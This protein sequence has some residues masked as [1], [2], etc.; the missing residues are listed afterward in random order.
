MATVFYADA[1]ELATLTNTFALDSVAT[2]P[3][4]V[5]LTVTDPTGDATTYT[6]ADSEITKAATGVYTKDIAV[7]TAGTWQYLWVGTGAVSDAT[8]GIWHV[9]PSGLPSIINLAEARGWLRLSATDDDMELAEIL[10]AASD[11]CEDMTGQVWRRR[12]ITEVHDTPGDSSVITLRRRP[13]ESITQVLVSGSAVTDYVLDGR[14]GR[15]H[16][17]QAIGSL[18]WLY[19]VQNTSIT[20]VAAPIDGIVPAHIRRGLKLLV[21]HIWQTQRGGL[22]RQAG[23][24]SQVAVDPRT[25]YSFPRRVLEMW[26]VSELAGPM[27][28]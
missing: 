25:G 5:S 22:P 8:A 16:R 17:G 21:Q 26:G 20:Y 15:L 28:G 14:R 23:A 12:T 13:V 10:L 9:E 3:D 2:D 18:P 11:I 4:A 27:V 24:S 7:P 6:Y 19:G 1:S